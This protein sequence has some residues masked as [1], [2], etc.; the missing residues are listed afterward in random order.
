MGRKGETTKFKG[1][2][3][4]PSEAAK[5]ERKRKK[6]R[7]REDEK[8]A[9]RLGARARLN[10]SRPE[11]PVCFDE[12]ATHKL[13]PCNH[14]YCLHPARP[15]MPPARQLCGLQAGP[16]L[17]PA[18]AQPGGLLAGG[19]PLPLEL[20]SSSPGRIYL[21]T[22]RSPRKGARGERLRRAHA[23]HAVET[24]HPRESAWALLRL[25]HHTVVEEQEDAHPCRL[26]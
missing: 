15:G 24:R 19:A 5:K 25:M 17:P 10:R 9:E 18:P 13:L 26:R 12:V 14:N 7:D 20:A 8:D 6:K 4:A 11:C 2:K 23:Q 22:C 16:E 21:S 3:P 1:A